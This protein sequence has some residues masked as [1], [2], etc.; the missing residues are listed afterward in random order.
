MKTKILFI[1]FFGL[2]NSFLF[3]QG[4]DNPN[5][6]S[7]KIKVPIITDEILIGD[8]FLDNKRDYNTK[9]EN[10]KFDIYTQLKYIPIYFWG[11]GSFKGTHI[12]EVYGTKT[13]I[14]VYGTIDFKTNRGVI[15]I[16]QVETKNVKAHPMNVCDF[17]Y[18]YSYKYQYKNLKVSTILSIGTKEKDKKTS[19]FFKPDENTKLT[20]DNYKYIED[21]KC[22][23]QNYSKE[24]VYK[25]INEDYLKEKLSSHWSYFTF[26]VNW[27]GK[28][29]DDLIKK[30]I[31]VTK[32]RD[33]E[34]NW[35]PL[36]VNYL[37]KGIEP[38]PN[39]IGVYPSKI[40]IINENKTEL[41]KLYTGL[42]NGFPALII[43]DLAKIPDIKVLE[44]TNIDKI[45]Q[46][47]KLSES[48]LVKVD[49]KFENKLMKEEMAVIVKLEIDAEKETFNTKCYVQ[50]K[51]KEIVIESSNLPFR[52]IFGIQ[53]VLIKEILKEVIK[54]FNIS[55]NLKKIFNDPNF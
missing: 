2:L 49:T 27:N 26:N 47:I 24:L 31:T 9:N 23:K 52:E 15:I 36:S 8:H 5:Y 29:I 43:A 40:K 21:T 42:Q 41:T 17:D 16:T 19:Y 20:I 37:K 33:K 1:V 14:E 45:L 22:P 11:K 30:S 4:L 50:S 34:P 6:I 38:E 7:G 32:L 53:R 10:V 44:R 54:Q 18:E 51:N 3:S 35:E 25:N 13:K 46:E 12:E 48:G 55:V 28:T 39:S